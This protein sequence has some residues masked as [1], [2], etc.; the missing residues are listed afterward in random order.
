VIGF[1]GYVSIPV[2]LAASWLKIPL[3]IHEQNSAAGLA[4]RF[5]A[6][7]ADTIALTYAQAGTAL[8]QRLVGASSKRGALLHLTGNPVRSALLGASRDQAR[9]SLGLPTDARMLLVFGGSLGA[10]HI[11]QALLDQ[12]EELMALP[13]LHVFQISGAK[14]YDSVRAKLDQLPSFAERWHLQGYCDR[15]GEVLTA[16]DVV[17][18]RAGAT[19]LAEI[20]AI[21]VPALLVPYP[22][23]TDDHQTSN[24]QAMVTAGAALMIPDD[25]LDSPHF[26]ELLMKLL[27]SGELRVTMAQAAKG[28]GS[29]NATAAVVDLALEMAQSKKR[30]NRS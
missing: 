16:A 5:L 21:G 20:S 30:A 14:D 27:N 7:R 13:D 29:A 2:G 6:K 19:S 24:A 3:L 10:R 1:G 28:L 15:M 23:A 18:S 25:E 9:Q 26:L 17:V 4:N 11:N 22:Y 12:A 8:G